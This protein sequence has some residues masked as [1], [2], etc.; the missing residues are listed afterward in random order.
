MMMKSEEED[1]IDSLTGA[2]GSHL[3]ISNKKNI[4]RTNEKSWKRKSHPHAS[5]TTDGLRS[6]ENFLPTH[7]IL[8]P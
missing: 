2:N 6:A 4:D 3:V 7:F 5:I 8:L 1:E